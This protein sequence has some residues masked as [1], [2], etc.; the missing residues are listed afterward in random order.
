VKIPTVS[1]LVKKLVRSYTS[2][3]TVHLRALEQK[4]SNTP[5]RNRK[6]EIVKLKTKINQVETKRI[7]QRSNK[8]KSWFFEN[9]NLIDIS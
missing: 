8:T 7:I 5:R 6:Q 9:I 2:N 4:E 1:A 3:L